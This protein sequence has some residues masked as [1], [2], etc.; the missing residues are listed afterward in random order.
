M[1]HQ[2]RKLLFGKNFYSLISNVNLRYH[3]H[4]VED[5]VVQCETVQEEKCEDVTQGYSTETRCTKWPRRVCASSR[6]RVKK[7]TPETHCAKRP[8][9]LCGP[10]LCPIEAGA[11]QCQ[12]KKET[13]RMGKGQRLTRS[14]R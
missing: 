13:V 4:D 10:G 8:V 11:E 12:E 9:Q 7:Y 6:Q 2:V 1:Y 5:D 3:E 14:S